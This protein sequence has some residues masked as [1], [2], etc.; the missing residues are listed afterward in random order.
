MGYLRLKNVRIV[1]QTCQMGH[2]G[3]VETKIKQG[4]A[5]SPGPEIEADDRR[6]ATGTK[7]IF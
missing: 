3:Q 6:H 1:N 7:S 2:H 5:S 4:E